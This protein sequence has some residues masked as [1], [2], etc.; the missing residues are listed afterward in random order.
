MKTSQSVD[1]VKYVKSYVSC[2][3]KAAF[4]WFKNAVKTVIFWNII[5]I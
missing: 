5:T 3:T 2:V 4:I 1:A